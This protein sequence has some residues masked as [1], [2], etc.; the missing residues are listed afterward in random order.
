MIAGTR[1]V[2]RSFLTALRLAA[3]RGKARNDSDFMIQPAIS[4]AP[5]PQLVRPPLNS[6]S[7]VTEE[8]LWIRLIA[9]PHR[10]ATD[11][12]VTFTPSID[13]RKTVSVVISSSIFDFIRRLM[14]RSF[15]IAWDTQA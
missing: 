12:V 11:S 14:P 13:G 3:D 5:P 10:P 8:L 7:E 4:A 9:S 1:P 2:A 15:K 6:N